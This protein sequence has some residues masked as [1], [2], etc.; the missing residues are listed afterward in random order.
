MQGDRVTS[1]QHLAIAYAAETSNWSAASLEVFLEGRGISRVEQELIWPRGIRSAARGL[2]D[3]ADEQMCCVWASVRE[4]KLADIIWQRFADNQH[5]KKSVGMLARS[6]F[7]HPI[8]TLSRTVQT[9]EH[10]LQCRGGYR[11]SGPVGRFAERWCLVLVYSA[12]VLVWLG[13]K[14]ESQNRTRNATHRLLK[15]I[16][17]S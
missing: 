16:G 14:S 11:A 6:D 17:T 9:V 15:L 1:K 4:A 13:D 2:N 10:M 7:F 5:L 3:A 12:S 8:D